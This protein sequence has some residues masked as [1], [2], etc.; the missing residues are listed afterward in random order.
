MEDSEAADDYTEHSTDFDKYNIDM[1]LPD[2]TDEEYNAFLR[3]DD[4]S[5]EETDYLLHLIKDYAYRWAVIWDRYDFQSGSNSNIKTQDN[6]NGD[7]TA[8]ATLPFAPPKARTVEDLKARFYEIQ[9]KLMK[10]RTPEASMDTEQYA[11]YEI[12]TKFNPELEKSRKQLAS[13]LMNRNMD[14]V[15]EEEF[16]LAELQRI[17]MAANRLDAERDE[18]RARL[19]APSPAKP[20]DAGLASFQSSQAL[21]ALFNQLIQQDKSK[22]R[23][24]GNGAAAG[25]RLSLSA[26]DIIN[27]PGGSQQAQIAAANRR[28]ST[29]QPP[30]QTP[31]RQLAPQQEYRFNVSTHDRLTS[32]VTFGSDK[33]LKMRQAKSN[34]QT[35][36]IA[37]A[38]ATLGIPDI[39]Q[40]PTSKVGEVF[41]KLIGKVGK[42]LDVRKVREKEEAECRVLEAMK[43]RRSGENR[44]EESSGANN[45]SSANYTPAKS[46]IPDSQGTPDVDGEPDDADEA[47][48]DEE[49]AEDDAEDAEEGEEDAEED[50]DGDGDADEDAEGDE[51]D[52]DEDA[53]GDIETAVQTRQGSEAVSVS[54]RAQSAGHKRSASVLSQGSSKSTKRARKQ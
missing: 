30:P 29:A 1:P 50:A 17:N 26:N 25:G 13:A 11:L 37:T 23:V 10:L 21:A 39:V 22:K 18:L 41:E 51:D 54:T 52:E 20:G 47:E 46:E 38:L 33:L 2:F 40:I 53:E 27:T 49:D 7:S 8:L 43:A 42:L 44:G 15:K 35:Q 16:L 19:E 34:V 32:G 5:R 4:W 31:V 14:E 45:E 24:V 28:Q 3:S 9:A 6:V 12:Y 48:V 36:K